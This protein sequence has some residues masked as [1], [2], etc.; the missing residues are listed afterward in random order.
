MHPWQ[1]F[2]SD[3]SGKRVLIF[4]LGLLG[5]AAGVARTMAE[6]GA[7]VRATDVKPAQALEKTLTSLQDVDMTYHLGEHVQSDID[8]AD[9]IVRNPSVPWHHPLLKTARETGKQIVMD[10]QLFVTYAKI[11]SIGITGTRGKTT[12][13][14]MLHHLLTNTTWQPLL[15]GNVAGTCML[16][17]LPNLHHYSKPIALM[18][19]SSWQLQ[20]FAAYRI[21]PHIG[22]V[23]NFYPDHQNVYSSMEEYAA[24]KQAIYRF[25]TV[26]DHT[27]LNRDLPEA[28]SWRQHVQG[29]LHWFSQNDLSSQIALKVAGEHNRANAAAVNQVGEILEIDTKIRHEALSSF[30]GVPFRFETIRQLRGVTYI[31]DTTSTTPVAT[32]AAINACTSPPLIIVGGQDK[33]LPL[34]ELIKTLNQKTRRLFLL[35]GG[36]TNRIKKALDASLVAGEYASLEDAVM[37]AHEIATEGDI[38]LLSP[39]FT[40]FGLFHNEFHRGEVFNTAVEKL[41]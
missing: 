12:T 9:V 16:D 5:G 34:D 22:V 27:V 38:V 13:T 36:G 11:P 21:S 18:E 32:I 30:T 26:N 19:L 8:W 25:Q 23:T 39:G 3:F 20:A 17:Y 35:P 24:D 4:G 10:A 29:K 15:G 7:M 31:N 33:Q 6:A 28:Y 2:Q 41:V 37:A 1:Q 40:S 14:M